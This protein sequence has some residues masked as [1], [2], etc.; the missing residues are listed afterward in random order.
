MIGVVAHD[1]GGAEII[2]SYLRRRGLPFVCCLDGPALG[3][4]QRKFADVRQLPLASVVEASDWLLC[5]TSFYSDLEWQAL[6]LARKSGRRAITV[7]D[8]WVNY[9]DRFV[10]HGEQCLPFEIW[11]GDQIALELARKDLAEVPLK[12]EPNAYLLDLQDEI[13]KITPHTREANDGLSILYVCEPLRDD[14]LALYNDERFWGYTEEEALC[15]FLTHIEW[16]GAP[17]SRIVVRAHPQEPV[18]K[19]AW[20]MEQFALPIVTGEN[21]TLLEQVA[22]SDVVAG[23]ASMAMVV[24]LIAG[25]RVVSCVPPGGKTVRLPH[26]EIERMDVAATV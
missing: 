11:V 10:R 12:L 5:G 21:R 3:V 15:H 8:H 14:G 18:D 22:D 17:I 16:L 13:A 9:P 2:S 20:A 4:F 19:Y 24:G 7:L 1:A 23:C 26:P 25:K 6:R